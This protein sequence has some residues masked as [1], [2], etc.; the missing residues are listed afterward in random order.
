MLLRAKLKGHD[1]I[2]VNFVNHAPFL[3]RVIIIFID[4]SLVIKDMMDLQLKF[5]KIMK[6]NI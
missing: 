2:F 1:Q 4:P 5:G 3:M 6:L